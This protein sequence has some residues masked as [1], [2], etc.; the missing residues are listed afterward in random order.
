MNNYKLAFFE[1]SKEKES[2]NYDVDFY[3]TTDIK[4]TI[5]DFK[6]LNHSEKFHT[7]ISEINY[8][9][10]NSCFPSDITS[11]AYFLN[12]IENNEKD[13]VLQ[14]VGNCLMQILQKYNIEVDIL[15]SNPQ[16]FIVKIIE[17]NTFDIKK[18]S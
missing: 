13:S 5:Y 4:Y 2:K 3:L 1:I 10:P 18:V 6:N 17:P 11:S 16:T 9:N 7:C 15:T 12:K 8:N 14:L